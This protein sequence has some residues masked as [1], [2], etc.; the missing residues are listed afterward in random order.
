MIKVLVA[1][2]LVG[3][4]SA[5]SSMPTAGSLSGKIEFQSD[6]TKRSKITFVDTAMPLPTSQQVATSGALVATEADFSPNKADYLRDALCHA[7]CERYAKT[8]IKV[9]AFDAYFLPDDREWG[10]LAPHTPMYVPPGTH[11]GAAALG[12]LL[13]YGIVAIAGSK[14]SVSA[15]VRL[16]VEVEGKR[17]NGAGRVTA[18]KPEDAP[19]AVRYATL[20]AISEFDKPANDE[21][22]EKIRAMSDKEI[23]S[24]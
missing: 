18:S 15:Y 11:P 22:A 6:A 20:S 17:L 9:L 16:S 5:C 7:D 13:G 23:K 12:V 24:E 14:Q 21:I 4:L 2:L 8:P 3:A 19:F 10:K 1:L